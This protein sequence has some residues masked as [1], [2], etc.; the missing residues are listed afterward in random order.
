[1]MEQIGQA[2]GPGITGKGVKGVGHGTAHLAPC[3]TTS[4]WASPLLYSV[5]SCQHEH[6]DEHTTS[7]ASLPPQ[8]QR[9]FT[10]HHVVLSN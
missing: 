2:H 8:A 10:E 9:S 5:N 1:M 4:T 3:L 6:S 7:I